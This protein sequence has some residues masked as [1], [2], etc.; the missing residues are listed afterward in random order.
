M[1]L[2][3]LH[4][5]LV[6]AL[7]FRW[8]RRW[9]AFAVVLLGATLPAL[10]SRIQELARLVPPDWRVLAFGFELKLLFW[11]ESAI[12]LGLGLFIAALPRRPSHPH[13]PYCHYDL[14]GLGGPDRCP[15]CGQALTAAARAELVPRYHRGACSPITPGVPRGTSGPVSLATGA[16]PR[17]SAGPG[18]G[19]RPPGSSGAG[20]P[21]LE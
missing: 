13:C 10:I 11:A 14:R 17:R 5:V 2:F 6:W 1:I 8:R 3:A 9:P 4:A 20:S 21:A 7:A 12:V 18:P 16:M 15:E 19:S